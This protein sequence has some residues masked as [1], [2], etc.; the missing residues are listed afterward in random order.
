[1]KKENPEGFSF[2]ISGVPGASTRELWVIPLTCG[3][4]II[5]PFVA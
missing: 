3:F 2:T 4:G 1:M 5:V